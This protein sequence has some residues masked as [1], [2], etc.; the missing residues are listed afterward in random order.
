MLAVDSPHR[1]LASESPWAGMSGAAVC[2]GPLL[3]GV[4]S[5]DTAGFSSRRV[6]ITPVS[7]LAAD[8]EAGAFAASIGYRFSYR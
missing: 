5:S 3:F 4:V 1:V 7:A 8:P 2:C 6:T